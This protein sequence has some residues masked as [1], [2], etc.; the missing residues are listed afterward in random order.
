M[1][2]IDKN[3]LKYEACFVGVFSQFLLEISVQIHTDKSSIKFYN[4]YS[5]QLLQ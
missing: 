5:T 2:Y 4:F 3:V 1:K